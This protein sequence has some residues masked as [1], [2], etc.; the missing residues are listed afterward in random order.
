MVSAAHIRVAPFTIV[1]SKNDLVDLVFAQ[2]VS[3]GH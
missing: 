3:L 2:S 1:S